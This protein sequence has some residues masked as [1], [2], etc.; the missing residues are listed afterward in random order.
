MGL[1]RPAHSDYNSV[2]NF[3]SDRNPVVHAEKA[4]VY[5]KEDMVTLRPGRE[6]AWLDSGIEALLKRVHCAIV[7][8]SIY[9]AAKR[10][11]R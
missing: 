4:W 2:V 1:N 7:E 5:W 10:Q 6:H 11:S 8:V 3:V 9:R